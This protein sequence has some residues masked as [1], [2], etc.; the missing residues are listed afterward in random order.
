[1]N[2]KI[3]E[4][5]KDFKQNKISKDQLKVMLLSIKNKLNNQANLSLFDKIKRFILNYKIKYVIKI[6]R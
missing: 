1:M 2:K 5:M 3:N 4:L 6:T